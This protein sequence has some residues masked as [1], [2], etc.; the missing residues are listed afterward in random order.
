VVTDVA[1]IVALTGAV[2]T[3]AVDVAVKVSV[4]VPIPP[5]GVTV[6]ELKLPVIPAGSPVTARLTF[7]VND[8]PVR[9]VITSVTVAPCTTETLAVLPPPKLIIAGLFDTCKAKVVVPVKVALLESV[10]VA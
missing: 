8:P 6:A 1:V 4:E 7:P 2:G 10:A 3:A 5:D 9:I